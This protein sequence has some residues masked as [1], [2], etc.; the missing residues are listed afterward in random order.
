MKNLI[1]ILSVFCTMA[2]GQRLQPYVVGSFNLMPAGYASTA[3]GFGGGLEFNRPYIVVDSYAGYDTGK[4][5]DDGT[6][7]NIKGHD[8][9]L[10][11]FAGYKHGQ[12]YFGVGA[13][14]SELSTT[15]YA[16]G[17]SLHPEIGV[18]R[19]WSDVARTQ[20]AYMARPYH[21]VTSYPD[22]RVCH[23]CG[24]GSQGADISVWLPSPAAPGHFFARINLMLFQF[25][26]S[27]TDP[28]NI[29]MTKA[30]AANKHLG[31]LTEVMVGWRF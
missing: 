19:D 13:R 11:G 22:G 25:H 30:Q 27:F 20:I 2:S 8:R 12:N 5:A 29:P 9:Y 7:G 23:G 31:D 6:P 17:G 16:K 26:D 24:S 14:W 15:N 21:E 28:S 3:V 4:K 18:G 1:L 10:R